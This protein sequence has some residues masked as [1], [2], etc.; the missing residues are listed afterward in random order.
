[1]PQIFPITPTFP[2]PNWIEDP[3]LS[4]AASARTKFLNGADSVLR[5]TDTQAGGSLMVKWDEISDV[6]LAEFLIFWQLVDTIDSFT[7]PTAFFRPEWPA[8]R[9][10]N[11]R[12]LSATGFWRFNEKPKWGELNLHSHMLS[13]VIVSS[14]N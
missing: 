13:A 4:S 11:Y 9:V 10:A 14:L 12:S 6:A 8:A 2:A 3:Q 1:M 7:L 5:L